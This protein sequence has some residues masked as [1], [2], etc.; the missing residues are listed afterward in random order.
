MSKNHNPTHKPDIGDF[1]ERDLRP[2]DQDEADTP[3]QQSS[4]GGGRY[5]KSRVSAAKAPTG[6]EQPVPGA[7]PP[8][9]EPDYSVDPRPKMDKHLKDRILND[10]ETQ[11][12]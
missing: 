5:E 8:D 3:G 11:D 2:E 12:R 6:D 4:K 9:A 10:T 7:T 1:P